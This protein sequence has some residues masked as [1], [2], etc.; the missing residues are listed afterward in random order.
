MLRFLV[1][2]TNC[3]L[4]VI[5][6]IGIPAVTHVQFGNWQMG[7][8]AK[9]RLLIF[10]GLVLAAIGNAVPAL[11]IKKDQDRHFFWEWS[12]LFGFLLTVEYAYTSGYLNF[13]WLKS[14]LLWTQSHL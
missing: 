1:K 13:G 11:L 12:A 6:L 7:S 10:F 8:A 3:I 2:V 5:I 4:L 14:G 9:A